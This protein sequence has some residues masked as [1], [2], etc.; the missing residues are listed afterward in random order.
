MQVGHAGTPTVSVAPG[1][2]LAA[3]ADWSDGL[4][5][6]MLRIWNVEQ[7]R[8]VCERPIG[9][10][11][12]PNSI[13]SGDFLAWSADARRLA[14]VGAQGGLVVWD[15]DKCDDPFVVDRFRQGDRAVSANIAPAPHLG[16]VSTL[17]NDRTLALVNGVPRIV[18]PF[19]AEPNMEAPQTGASV[20][21]VAG[22]RLARQSIQSVP[23]G[24]LG[25]SAD[26]GVVL[27]GGSV[28]WLPSGR[29]WRTSELQLDES[30]KRAALGTFSGASSLPPV[31]S[32]AMVSPTGR[33]IA[34]SGPILGGAMV[35]VIDAKERR[36]VGKKVLTTKG[37]LA[38]ASIGTSSTDIQEGR[39][40]WALGGGASSRMERRAISGMAFS[41]D[42]QRLIVL[43]PRVEA[44]GD[45]DDP[46][47][48]ALRITD[49]SVAQVTWIRGIVVPD[50]QP[51]AEFGALGNALVSSPDAKVALLAGNSSLSG[52]TLAAVD[53]Q[54]E[55]L[56][57]RP[58][59]NVARGIDALRFHAEGLLV[60]RRLSGG[61]APS[62]GTA[63]VVSGEVP[64]SGGTR[65]LLAWTL[66]SGSA[67]T[68]AR[69]AYRTEDRLS[70]ISADS[71]HWLRGVDLPDGRRG[72]AMSN[73]SEGRPLWLHPF[74]ADD[75]GALV[76]R[77]LALAPNGRRAAIVLDRLV[78]ER[79]RS[80]VERALAKRRA[81]L[82]N[83]LTN[84][85][86]AASG[87][88]D[89]MRRLQE[90]AIRDVTEA[91]SGSKSNAEVRQRMNAAVNGLQRRASEIRRDQ[92]ARWR[93]AE[94]R[95]RLRQ[96][97][98]HAKAETALRELL[99]PRLVVLDADSGDMLAERRILNIEPSTNVYLSD[100]GRIV[101]TDGEAWTLIGGS[102]ASF[103]L[104][105]LERQPAPVIGAAASPGGLI[106]GQPLQP[107]RAEAGLSTGVVRLPV[108]DNGLAETNN[109]GTMIA[110]AW[111]WGNLAVFDRGETERPRLKLRIPG[112]HVSALAF[113]PDSRILAVGTEE[114][115]VALFETEHGRLLARLFSFS[116][117]SWTVVDEQGRFD[118][119]RR[120]ANAHLHWVMPDDPMQALSLESLMYDYYQP[121]LLTRILAGEKLPAVRPVSELNRALPAVSIERIEPE[122]DRPG[123][124][125]VTVSVTGA[126]ARK[127]N[128]LAG[129]IE[130]RLMRN[131]QLV[132]EGL[133]EA[134]GH[135]L[136][137]EAK[138]TLMF[139]AIRLPSGS[140]PVEF[141]AYAFNR[142]WIKSETVHRI[143]TRPHAEGRQPHSRAFVVAIGV[144]AY[145]NAQWNDLEFAVNDAQRS[146]SILMDRLRATG[147]FAQVV[148]V[149]LVSEAGGPANATKPMIRA[150]FDV[151]AG[152]RRDPLLNSVP[153]AEQL[154]AATPDDTVF[155]F[156]SGHG[157][158]ATD[159]G[160]R[161]EH[162]L[163]T[164]DTEEGQ[165]KVPSEGPGRRSISSD[166]LSQWMRLID[167]G[168]IAMV[169]D[170]CQSAAAVESSGREPG[171]MSSRGPMSARGLGWLAYEKGIRILTASQSD[172]DA[173]EF[174][175]L[176]H[177]LLTHVLINEG[178]IDGRADSQ[179]ADQRIE[180]VEWLKF[181]A[182][183][184][185]RLAHELKAG[186][187]GDARAAKPIRT[188]G[189]SR[190]LPAL[191]DFV[192][193]QRTMIIAPVE[194]R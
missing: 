141:S 123:F 64:A 134:T 108:P 120:E 172:S 31:T 55:A 132:A 173:L 144:N 13:A 91:A 129:A 47:L 74:V 189:E 69:D 162:H 16:Y 171:P 87:Q 66:A 58:W 82:P 121:R 83:P 117:D 115:E 6:G 39:S 67:S 113:S 116:D 26:G 163:I 40:T 155:V 177:G 34:V 70:A 65:Q 21:T 35:G 1:G 126:S 174:P 166:E 111:G 119:N 165:S 137:S 169:I 41:S 135:A 179:P 118:T 27:M 94:H 176:Q 50:L 96:R 136:T 51:V 38:T 86:F 98:D 190:Q 22:D 154:A 7:G 186:T 168:V 45:R 88:I 160:G 68:I 105:T 159:G 62:P 30:G 19:D 188:N 128:Q 140:E 32:M 109:A 122:P 57:V 185:P 84:Q 114:G 11:V 37:P 33:W 167:A 92:G 181:G 180:L 102:G 183:R 101:L 20:A 75:G 127:H 72:V 90:E 106:V 85:Q 79:A 148:A 158:T 48:V 175:Q 44:S 191:F 78:D 138:Q 42:E 28:T 142:D 56:S 153:G 125:R 43:R 112:R 103:A 59:V 80:E 9:E 61:S 130:L 170:A 182:L 53:L 97:E 192:S 8:L 60:S 150:A 2:R 184:A 143:H 187:S 25:H 81:P 178:L 161:R 71:R 193:R 152:K 29:H 12:D 95:T 4:G 73:S 63:A 147:D 3:T 46:A 133:T 100:G 194:G 15:L 139:R 23:T 89:A 52:T 110:A 156:F 17:S 14:A 5:S 145:N 18:R 49:L 93:D 151:L 10:V 24:P 104:H 131:G 124:V 146:A 149:P 36:F 77:A 157:K 54:D 164:S 99:Q 107:P 76:P